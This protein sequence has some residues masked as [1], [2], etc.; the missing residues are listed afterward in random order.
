MGHDLAPKYTDEMIAA[1]DTLE[2]WLRRACQGAYY[3]QF[4]V[5]PYENTFDL[6]IN[7]FKSQQGDIELQAP[8]GTATQEWVEDYVSAETSAFIDETALVP[9]ATTSEVTAAISTATTDMATQT[10]VGQQNYATSAY[11]DA[12]IGNV[13]NTN[14]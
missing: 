6:A 14:F 8:E 7:T 3:V 9:Y 13:L 5:I 1:G 11:V 2:L 12:Q 10:W 4:A